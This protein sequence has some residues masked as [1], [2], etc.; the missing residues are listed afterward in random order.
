MLQPMSANPEE[1][2][3]EHGD[4]LE[5]VPEVHRLAMRQHVIGLQKH[6]PDL[7]KYFELLALMVLERG[8]STVA[9]QYIAL[10]KEQV[11]SLFRLVKSSV[12]CPDETG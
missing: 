4:L 5:F 3:S 11:W 8:Q 1:F 6:S 2:W 12:R 9:I 7:F 10:M